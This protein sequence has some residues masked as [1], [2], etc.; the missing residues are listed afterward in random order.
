MRWDMAARNERGKTETLS[1]RLDP[2]TK[3]MLE[4]VARVRGQS[5][6]TIVERAIR[7]SSAL[8]RKSGTAVKNQSDDLN[9]EDFWD[10]DEGVR[11]MKLLSCKEYPSTYDEDELKQFIFTHSEFFYRGY[12]GE[13]PRR[14]YLRV[15]WPKIEEYRRVW[16]EERGRNYWAAGM[17]MAADL[18]AARIAAPAWPPRT[19]RE[20]KK[21]EPDSE[22][23]NS[24]EEQGLRADRKMLSSDNG[25]YRNP[26]ASA[27]KAVD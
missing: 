1:L 11:M 27:Q 20:N 19:S 12:F 7:S 9:W 17:A 2:K 13:T 15:L 5:I 4:F 10:P 18:T 3:F 25:D 8:G 14:P 21:L 26:P 22:N 24:E 6:T 16:I 23:L